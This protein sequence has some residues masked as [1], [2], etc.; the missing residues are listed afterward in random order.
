MFCLSYSKQGWRTHGYVKALP[1][2]P[3]HM[4]AASA[5]K[6]TQGQNHDSRLA[7]QVRR[8]YETMGSDPTKKSVAL[9][10]RLETRDDT[11]K[12]RVSRGNDAYSKA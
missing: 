1:H 10:V 11:R 3:S 6:T 12:R 4:E 2:P 5:P 7:N 9:R 8:R